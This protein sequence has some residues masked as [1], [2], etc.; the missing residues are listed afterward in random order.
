MQLPHEIVLKYQKSPLF[1]Q[2][3]E[4]LRA[5][6]AVVH[7]QG[8]A[9]SLPAFLMAAYAWKY[10]KLLICM[11]RDREEAAYLL[12]DLENL[13]LRDRVFF[14]P[15]SYRRPYDVEETDNANILMR[16]ETLNAISEGK[17]R[18]IVTYPAALVE[19]VITREHIDK[20]TLRLT[21][22]EAVDPDFVFDVLIEYGFERDD[23]VYEPGQF[24]IRG[25]IIDVFSYAYDL[26][27]R[28]EFSGN[29]VGSIRS[30]DPETQL[31]K[32]HLTEIDILANIEQKTGEEF[33]IPFFEFIS[34]NALWWIFDPVSSREV[35]Q[36][37]YDKAVEAYNHLSGEIKRLEPAQLFITAADFQQ[38]IQK[39]SQVVLNG[40]TESSVVLWNAI[41]QP[42]FHKNF[43]L[44]F[45]FLQQNLIQQITTY[46]FSD[47]LRQIERI[48]NIFHDLIE[49]SK[50]T[51]PDASLFEPVP[52][53][54]R[55][56]FIDQELQIACFT[57][58]QI[59]ERYKRFQLKSSYSKN[60]SLT[61]R[62]LT[63]LNPGDYV[64][65]IDH[66]I[67]QFAG[68]EKIDV[69]GK[70]QEAVKLI[71]KDGDVIYVSIHSLHRIAKYTGKDAKPPVLNKIGSNTWQTLKAKTKKKVKELAF[72]LI[73]LYA[74][75]RSE[76]G[77]AYSADTYL[78]HELEAS[79]MY[80]DTPDQYKATQDVKADMEKPYPMDRLVC[81]DV[82]FGKTEVAIRAA[83][84]AVA[85][86][87]QVAVLVPTTILALQHYKTFSN[88]LKDFPCTVDYINRFRTAKEQKEVLKKLEE[89]KIDILIGT[90]KL[91][92]NDV[93]FKD[94]GLLIIDEEQ[95]F[96]VST[97]DKLK[98]LK[99]NV[100]TL[101]LSAT[102]IP[103]T[104]Q[105]SL[106]GARDL[107]IIRTPPPNRYPVQTELRGFNEEVIRDA[108][109]YEVNRNGQVFFIHN[110]IQNLPEIT[111][112]IQRLCPDVKIRYAHGQMDG[113]QLEEIMLEFIEGDIDVLVSTSIV[114]SG[115]DIPNANTIIINDAHNFGL[116]D[117][118]QMR[119]RVGRSNKKAFCYLLTP[120]IS[121]L[122]EDARKRLN[123]LVEFSDLGSGFNIAM[124]D[125]DIRGAGD[126][127][128]ADQSGF[129]NEMGYETYQKIL[130][131]ALQELKENEFRD[132]FEEEINSP[133]HAWVED[134]QIET[135][136]EILIPESY[137]NNITERLILYKELD[138]L[139]K[140]EEI[141][142]FRLRLEDRFGKLPPPAE[143][144]LDTIRLRILAKELG[145]EKI[146]LKKGS[147]IAYF[148][149]NPR[150]P[151][152]Q[153]EVFQRILQF[154][155]LPQ[156]RSIEMKQKNDKLGLSFS[157]VNTV[158]EAYDWLK[159]M[160]TFKAEEVV[161]K[162]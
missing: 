155:Q 125:L 37:Y 16:T 18:V 79:F 117:L 135:D 94:L 74:K 152:Y 30:F 48:K 78:Q 17:A 7:L 149:T 19:K 70:P 133:D 41:P 114:E 22:G 82:G 11:A 110:R 80:E 46:I 53:A 8:T 161:G 60:Q 91:V 106:L 130:N 156:S 50:K 15:E 144:L 148:V 54:I 68:L 120:P 87:K 27:F 40:P 124:K 6:P 34:S 162:E 99:T 25:G 123:A 97:K 112:M 57:D 119:G 42:E 127:L 32:Q 51:Q 132:V 81:G 143:A 138:G 2:L 108:I 3:E 28:I 44:L 47:Q 75:R 140:E 126:L 13:Y 9:G 146:I 96:G 122:T 20:K 157:Q 159:Q 103:R 128:G 52:F 58:H 43:N 14:Y 12:N 21:Q 113:K 137:V 109:M 73:K 33:R 64:T 63:N 129:I 90:H 86:G 83:F 118:H 77:H 35:V 84:K 95:K 76:K 101:T 1:H 105:F 145:I 116:S 65:H 158:A 92:G 56:G 36:K 139:E 71:Y 107:S 154:L 5:S 134:C 72:D 104:L 98:T 88:R 111:G 150:S 38:G 160:H 115:L 26:P 151:F 141:S 136:L 67:G 102:P 59:F 24:A 23:F 85:D 49:K 66:G 61:L 45:D 142:Q 153:S 93:K 147:F 10:D 121:T 89:G 69:N 4:Q 62:E 29:K 31:S 39:F 55:E 131:E 100:D